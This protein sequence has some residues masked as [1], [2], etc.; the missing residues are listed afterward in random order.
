MKGLKQSLKRLER[1]E[2]DGKIDVL[3]KDLGCRTVVGVHWT[4]EGEI[5]LFFFS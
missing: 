4:F 2:V 5:P 3:L 1:K